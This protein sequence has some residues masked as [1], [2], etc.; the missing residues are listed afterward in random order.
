MKNIA[1]KYPVKML[2]IPRKVS[3][4]GFGLKSVTLRCA[5]RKYSLLRILLLRILYYCAFMRIYASV[6]LS[7]Y[8]WLGLQK[9]TRYL[10]LIS[11]R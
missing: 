6:R 4:T 3:A 2:S 1:P 8:G 10:S 7:L 5:L 9:E 11:A